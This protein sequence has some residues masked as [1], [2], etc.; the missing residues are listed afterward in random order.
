MRATAMRL[1][2]VAVQILEVECRKPAGHLHHA[3]GFFWDSRPAALQ[4]SIEVSGNCADHA[5]FY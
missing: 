2:K 1:E 4:T 3:R 5:A